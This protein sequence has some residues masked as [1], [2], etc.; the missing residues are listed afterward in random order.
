[1]TYTHALR[2]VW[3]VRCF[4]IGKRTTIALSCMYRLEAKLTLA[5]QQTARIDREVAS[6][7]CIGIHMMQLCR[8][9]FIAYISVTTRSQALARIADR[10]ASQQI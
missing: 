6:Y 2:G 1:L 3:Y 7:Y 10:T 5:K 8:F 4:T 9:C